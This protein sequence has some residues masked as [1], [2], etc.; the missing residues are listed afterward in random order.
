MRRG[1]SPS[2][3]GPV[4]A[5]PVSFLIRHRRRSANAGRTQNHSGRRRLRWLRSGT[6]PVA[7][8]V[9]KTGEAW[10]PHAG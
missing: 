8:P 3:A 6:G 1:L 10:Q 5:G 2:E 7:Q 4:A 9:F